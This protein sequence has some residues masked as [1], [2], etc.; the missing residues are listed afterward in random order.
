MKFNWGTGI[1]IFFLS[2]VVLMLFMAYKCFQTDFDLV[3]ED[4]YAKELVYQETIKKLNNEKNLDISFFI[5]KSENGVSIEFPKDQAIAGI[6]GTVQFF[7]SSDKELDKYFQLAN[8]PEGT[9]FFK[10]ENFQKGIYKVLVD[11]QSGETS[12]YKEEVIVF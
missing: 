5:K 9:Y 6:T 7:R 11:W 3:T 8:N 2:F 10:A 4:Y 1:T 12:Y